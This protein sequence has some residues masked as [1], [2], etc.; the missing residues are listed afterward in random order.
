MKETEPIA[1]CLSDLKNNERGRI[2]RCKADGAMKQKLI[3]MGFIPGA[4][5]MLVRSAPLRD[6]LQIAVQNYLVAL[7]RSEALLVEVDK[8]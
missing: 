3:S 7:R 1:L 6:P 2:L 8:I 4:E 5:I